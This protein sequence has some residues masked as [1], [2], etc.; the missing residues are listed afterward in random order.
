MRQHGTVYLEWRPLEWARFAERLRIPLGIALLKAGTWLS[1]VG[2]IT[3]S[4]AA[5]CVHKC[6]RECGPLSGAAVGGLSGLYIPLSAMYSHVG[7][8]TIGSSSAG[9]FVRVIHMQDWM[10][11]FR[12]ALLTG[13]SCIFPPYTKG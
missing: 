1:G 8:V 12:K 4:P 11:I 10:S 7:D 6:T 9:P 3:P 13:V 2:R 5:A